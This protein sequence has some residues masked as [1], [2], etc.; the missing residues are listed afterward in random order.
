LFHFCF[1]L[2][3]FEVFFVLFCFKFR[4]FTISIWFMIFGLQWWLS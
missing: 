1:V 3:G 4:V 2:V